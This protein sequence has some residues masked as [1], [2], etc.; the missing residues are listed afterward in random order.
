MPA[1]APERV[2][3]DLN[4]LWADL[5]KE[6]PGTSTETGVLRACAMTFIVALEPEDDVQSVGQ[7]IAQLIHEHPS[8]AIVLKPA[9]KSAAVD[10][11]V[12]AQCWMPFG[13]RQQ[14]CCEQIEITAPPANA[15]EASRL[16][17]GLLTPDLPAVAWS[18]GSVWLRSAGFSDLVPLMTKLIVDSGR[19]CGIS[20]VARL[21]RQAPHVAD[22]EWTRTTPTRQEIS[23]FFDDPRR[24]SELTSVNTIIVPPG[25]RYLGAWLLRAL[26]GKKLSMDGVPGHIRLEGPGVEFEFPIM[27]GPESDYE[28]LNEELGIIGPDPVFENVLTVAETLV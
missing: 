4:H 13:K 15:T 3:K 12:S 26:P 1:I 20:D 24:D 22:L 17:L 2:L 8:R 28:L 7:T 9:A 14:V 6:N 19:G 25:Q 5:A 10:A 18:R 21:R 11:H 16:M 23:R 27:P